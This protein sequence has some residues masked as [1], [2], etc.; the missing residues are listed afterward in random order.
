MKNTKDKPSE[1]GEKETIC[2]KM[3]FRSILKNNQLHP[4][5]TLVMMILTAFEDYELVV[6]AL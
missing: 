6:A 1:E 5:Q 4:V 2:T 3:T